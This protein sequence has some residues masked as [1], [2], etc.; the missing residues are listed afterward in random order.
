MEADWTES[1]RCDACGGLNDDDATWCAQCYVVFEVPKPPPGVLAAVSQRSDPISVASRVSGTLGDQYD[2]AS[3]L[4]GVWDGKPA[5]KC[6]RCGSFTSV[7]KNEC[8]C[9]GT[10]AE[11]AE[12]AASLT[13]AGLARESGRTTFRALGF[14]ARVMLVVGGLLAPVTFLWLAVYT[15]VR[16]VAR[17]MFGAPR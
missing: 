3:Q 17:W 7:E 5:W 4:F 16:R 15:L 6:A 14:S 11:A 1:K 8:G 9:G 13:T 10:F 2:G 12:S